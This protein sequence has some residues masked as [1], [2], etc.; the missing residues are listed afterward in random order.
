[1]KDVFTNIYKNKTWKDKYGTESGPGSSLECS[2]PY[3]NF[4]QDFC[5]IWNVRTILDIGC[6][7]FNLMKNFNFNDINYLGI[8]IVEHIIINNQT[9]Y[10][11]EHVKFRC[12]SFLDYCDDTVVDLLLCKD[13]IQHLSRKNVYRLLNIKNYKYA[14]Y[15][16]D[17]LDS[18][19]HDIED[20][21]HTP[22]DLSKNPYNVNC[23]CIFE[24][25]SCSYKKKICKLN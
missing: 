10:G 1:M 21:Q 24:W 15:T 5:K 6:G 14:L 18:V 9:L 2:Q 7:D 17:F 3:L 25:Q 16:N 8:D 20:G 12:Q 22:I 13:L 19:N 4:L 23:D 11:T